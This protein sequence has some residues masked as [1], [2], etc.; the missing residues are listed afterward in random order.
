MGCCQLNNT[1]KVKIEDKIMENVKTGNLSNLKMM[2]RLNNYKNRDFDI[3][4]LR[5]KVDE[6]CFVSLL[7]LCLIMNQAKMFDEVIKTMK[8]DFSLMESIFLEFNT[9]GLAIICLNNYILMLDVYLPRYLDWKLNRSSILGECRASLALTDKSYS[10]TDEVHLT[11]IQLACENGHIGIINALKSYCRDMN[12]IPPEIDLNYKS[13]SSGL[14][15]A[16][17]ACK[18]NNFNMIKYLHVN[19]GA[20]F[21]VLNN[22]SENAIQILASGSTESDLETVR[23]M[24]YLIDK[25][26][27]DFT[28]NY[29]E[30]LMMLKEPTSIDYFEKR[31]QGINIIATKLQTE[32]EGP[33][34][35]NR[36]S[37]ASAKGDSRFTF[38]K[39]FPELLKR[40]EINRGSGLLNYN[41]T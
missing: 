7:G 30:T 15:C 18:N 11:P 9:S 13:E 19:C 34:N 6:T 32:L 40:S 26:H 1:G 23:C 39:L 27:V 25:V 12:F 31:L 22:Y 35:L 33:T 16:L 14:N 17:I 36:G 21:S 28:Y 10:K 5:F 8:G 2:Y 29:Q 20:D 37:E 24:E 3:N 38:I 41:N 4:S